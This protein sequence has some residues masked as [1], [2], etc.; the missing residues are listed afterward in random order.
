MEQDRIL[1]YGVE[2]VRVRIICCNCEGAV[3][4][5]PR[6]KKGVP[7][8]C[9]QCNADWGQHRDTAVGDH[10]VAIVQLLDALLKV[11]QT[12][13][14]AAPMVRLELTIRQEP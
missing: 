11:T 7:N 8:W 4:M 13:T 12:D 5:I 1:V 14:L 6:E 2:D 10:K 9:P 3:V